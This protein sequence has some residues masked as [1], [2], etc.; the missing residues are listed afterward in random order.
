MKKKNKFN[1]I[2]DA[3]LQKYVSIQQMDRPY[4]L[5]TLSSET[6]LCFSWHSYLNSIDLFWFVIT[7]GLHNCLVILITICIP[8]ESELVHPT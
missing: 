8:V 4:D 3:Y 1:K 6:A 2:H 5:T 7:D